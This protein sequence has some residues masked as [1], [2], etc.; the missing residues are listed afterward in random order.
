M[1]LLGAFVAVK[2]I[3]TNMKQVFVGNIVFFPLLS[4]ILLAIVLVGFIIGSMKLW[5]WVLTKTG[6]LSKEEARGYPYSKPWKEQER[7]SLK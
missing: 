2:L 4:I 3:Y 5:G 7:N 1:G 6:I